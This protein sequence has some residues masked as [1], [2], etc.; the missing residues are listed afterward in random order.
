MS[1]V[2]KNSCKGIRNGWFTVVFVVMSFAGMSFAEVDPALIIDSPTVVYTDATFPVKCFDLPPSF[3]RKSATTF[4]VFHCGSWKKEMF[5]YE[6]TLDNPFQTRLPDGFMNM[7][8]WYADWF[9]SF[10]WVMSIYK[11]STTELLGFSH[12]EKMTCGPSTT[13]CDHYATGI[14]FSSNAGKNW[15]YCGEIA[16]PLIDSVNTG[17]V[18]F[19]VV[20]EYFYIYFNDGGHPA[21]ARAKKTDVIAAARNKTVSPWKKYFNGSWDLDASA[22]IGSAVITCSTP[23]INL[24]MHAKAA[25]IKSIGK[26]IIACMGKGGNSQDFYVYTSADGINWGNEVR[27]QHYS[28]GMP[29]YGMNVYSAFAGLGDASDDC[30]EVG[31]EFYLYWTHKLEADYCNDTYYRSRIR[32]TPTATQQP[33]TKLV[34]RANALEIISRANKWFVS[35]RQPGVHTI[36]LVNASGQLINSFLVKKPGEYAIK[37]NRIEKGLYIVGVSIDGKVKRGKIILR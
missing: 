20:G 30:N 9:W 37:N 24:D 7:N 16:N 35:I 34:E 21:V 32:V 22:G 3:L 28:K 26:Y 36:T 11:I 6:G 25:Y 1:R 10:A 8:G 4:S 33:S 29:A 5:L 12:V 31:N 19:I 18:P 13:N 27:L 17:G 14:S 23:G 15:T 2:Q